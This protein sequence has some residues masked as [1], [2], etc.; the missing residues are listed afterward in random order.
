M[1]PPKKRKNADL[2][3]RFGENFEEIWAFLGRSGVGGICRRGGLI[4]ARR[5]VHI[6]HK[7]SC[8]INRLKKYSKD[9]V[10]TLH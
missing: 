5:P 6:V 8:K 2:C 9:E 7:R 1:D 10:K 3:E 4:G